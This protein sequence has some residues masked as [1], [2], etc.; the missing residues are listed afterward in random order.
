MKKQGD[1]IKKLLVATYQAWA[2]CFTGIYF[3]QFLLPS[4]S[5][6][7]FP[8]LKVIVPCGVIT[9]FSVYDHLREV[10]TSKGSEGKYPKKEVR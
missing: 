4:K 10:F 6:A 2:R 9:L 7:D 3:F 1:L 5:F 8:S